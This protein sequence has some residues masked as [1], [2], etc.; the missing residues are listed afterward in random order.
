ML[1]FESVLSVA[2]RRRFGPMSSWLN[3]RLGWRI[4]KEIKKYNRLYPLK[5]E[6]PYLSL[7]LNL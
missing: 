5:T 4:L 6:N 1:S 2:S 7:A 3:P